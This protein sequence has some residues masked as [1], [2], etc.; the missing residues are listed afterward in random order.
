MPNCIPIIDSE[1]RMR[2]KLEMAKGKCY[3]NYGF[4]MG[5]TNENLDALKV[6]L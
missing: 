4:Y 3:G 1:A 6:C 2:D 5:A